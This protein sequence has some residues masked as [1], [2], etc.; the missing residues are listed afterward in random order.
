MKHLIMAKTLKKHRYL[1]MKVHEVPQDGFEQNIFRTTLLQYAVNE[2]GRFIPTPSDGW[3]TSFTAVASIRDEFKELEQE[4]LERVK[5]GKT[6][7]IEYFMYKSI[8]DIDALS[9]MSGFSKRKI[10]KHMDPKI[11][12]KLS[13]SILSQYALLFLIDI[14]EINNFI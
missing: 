8:M 6:S 2:E 3:E 14:A 13:D 1:S 11:F 9:K 5:Q 10:K 7:P 4:A 12:V